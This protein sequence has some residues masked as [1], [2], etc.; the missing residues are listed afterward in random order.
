LLRLTPLLDSSIQFFHWLYISHLQTKD[1][2]CVNHKRAISLRN[3]FS[4]K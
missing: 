2:D 1:T 4:L 3:D